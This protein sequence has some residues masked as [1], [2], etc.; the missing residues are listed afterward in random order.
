MKKT[1]SI[2]LSLVMLVSCLG[3][4]SYSA[5]ANTKS[6]ATVIELNKTVAASVDSQNL[7]YWIKFVPTKTAYYEFV[8]KTPVDT[9]SI[10]VSIYDATGD[11]VGYNVF[12]AFTEDYSTACK[13][14]K[15]KTY[16]FVLEGDGTAYTTNVTLKEHTKHTLEVWTFPAYYD[17]NDASE[18]YDGGKISFCACGYYTE[19]ATYYYPKTITLS[20]KTYTYNGKKKTPKVTVKDRKGNVISSSNYKVTY[21]NNTKPGQAT[22]TVTFNGVKYEGTMTTTFTIKPK[23]QTLSSVKSNKSKQITVKWKKDSNVSGYQVQYSTSS[24]FTSGTR[25]TITISKNTTTSKTISKLK[26]NKKYYVRVRAYK[27][28]DG[29]KVYGAWSTVKSVTTKK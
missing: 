17:A 27:T 18:R 28:I 7:N 15:N 2:L 9:G 22:V 25:K 12:D 29:K 19:D 10:G 11:W 5:L 23:K 8:C 6:T 14:T 24:K 16:Y 4:G 13:M 3:I 21:K 1:L 26:S 20:T